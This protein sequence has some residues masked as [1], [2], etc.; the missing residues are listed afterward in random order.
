MN[1]L[2]FSVAFLVSFSFLPFLLLHSTALTPT[3]S[4]VIIVEI[5]ENIRWKTTRSDR[6]R[7]SNACLL[8]NLY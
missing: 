1:D 5:P 8:L 3:S 6:L 2:F 7:M 4:L